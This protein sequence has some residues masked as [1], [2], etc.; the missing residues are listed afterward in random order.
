MEN[1]CD[2]TKCKEQKKRKEKEQTMHQEQVALK[3]HFH[4]PGTSRMMES[5]CQYIIKP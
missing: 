5:E 2:K 3:N 1:H 4:E